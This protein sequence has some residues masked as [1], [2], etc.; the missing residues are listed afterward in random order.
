MFLD[1]CVRRL[2]EGED[3]ASV[4]ADMRLHYRTIRSLNVKTCLVR[5]GCSPTPAF[6]EALEARMCEDEGA[7]LRLSRYASKLVSV[8]PEDRPLLRGLPP[9][10]P[11]N[12]SLVKIDR[13]ELSECKRLGRA[14][15]IQKNRV[16]V[17]VDGASLLEEARRVVLSPSEA[18]PLL[19]ALSLLLLTGRRTCELMSG[20]ARL[21]RLDAHHATFSGQAKRRS[22]DE[23]EYP[24]PL[25]APSEQVVAAWEHLLHARLGDEVLT[26]QEAS[27]R[28][29]SPLRRRLLSHGA[30]AQCKKVHAL[31]G[32]YVCLCLRAYEWEA[33]DAYVAASLLGHRTLHES[34]VY[35]PFDLGE[36][37]RYGV[38]GRMR[39]LTTEAPGSPAPESSPPSSPERPSPPG[40]RAAPR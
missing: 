22:S 1:E 26:R 40:R 37:E 19:L 8:L 5:Q 7:R 29:Q 4:L 9:R 27:V 30:F 15:A 13:R 6:R 34:L 28:Y 31:R 18:D 21:V 12:V 25:L 36:V 2:E 24:I 35:T 23:E 11:S 38:P 39:E 10:M 32:A 16:R 17:R 14:S 33:A 3:G 20:T